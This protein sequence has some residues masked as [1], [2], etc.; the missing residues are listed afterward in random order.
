MAMTGEMTREIGGQKRAK[1]RKQFKRQSDQLTQMLLK[2][3][4][5]ES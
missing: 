2:M 4:D 5:D 1:Q 3:E